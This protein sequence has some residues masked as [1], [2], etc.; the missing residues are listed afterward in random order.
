MS[1]ASSMVCVLGM[2]LPAAKLAK[3]ALPFAISFMSAESCGIQN[4]AEPDARPNPTAKIEPLS[5]C[6]GCPAFAPVP[7]PPKPLRSIKYVAQYELTWNNYLK[8]FDEGACDIPKASSTIYKHKQR[9]ILDRLSLYRIDWP[10][11]ILGPAEV[12]C[13]RAWLQKKVKY[14]VVLPTAAEWEWF[15]R[16]GKP[17]IKF[18][19]GNEAD[20]S[21]EALGWNESY[22]TI[23]YPYSF[24]EGGRFTFEHLAG[25]KVGSFAPNAWGI[26]DIMGNVME[27]T[28]DMAP[29]TVLSSK[30]EKAVIVKGSG[31]S[32]DDWSVGVSQKH[33]VTVYETHYVAKVA[34]RLIILED[35]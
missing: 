24:H 17:G 2:V 26:Y 28:S 10:I 30:N 3:W 23:I 20:V 6:D 13:Y 8:A 35:K 18:P 33:Y 29:S 27:L 15:A 34:V 25:L 21:K 5:I 19:W 11:V 12:E 9:D 32:W 1:G 31:L 7:T 16:S 4:G 22:S 14:K